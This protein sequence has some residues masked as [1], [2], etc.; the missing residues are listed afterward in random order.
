MN[1][2]VET[3]RVLIEQEGFVVAYSSME[4]R[5]VKCR[6]RQTPDPRRGDEAVYW[7]LVLEAIAGLPVIEEIRLDA[8]QNQPTWKNSKD[9]AIAAVA[10]LAPVIQRPPQSTSVL[11]DGN[12]GDI[13]VSGGGA[14]MTVAPL[15]IDIT[16][17]TSGAATSGQ[18]LT[19]DGAGGVLYTTPSG[20]PLDF[21]SNPGFVTIYDGATPYVIPI[22]VP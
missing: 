18:L 2:T 19:A 11:A 8:I 1:I 14:T 22:M 3:Y 17:I 21:A 13:I 20:F 9:G 12:Y 16:K 5:S 4:L 15:A 10:A 6:T 7:V